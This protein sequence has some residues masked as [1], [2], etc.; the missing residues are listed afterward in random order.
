M[1]YRE[2]LGRKKWTEVEKLKKKMVGLGKDEN[3][4]NPYLT[5]DGVKFGGRCFVQ[6]SHRLSVPVVSSHLSSHS[7]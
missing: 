4:N 2:K 6:A 1:E 5:L 3:I 7:V